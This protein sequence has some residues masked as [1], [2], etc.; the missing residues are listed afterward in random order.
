[1]EQLFFYN[2]S[3]RN[4]PDYSRTDFDSML[5]LNGTILKTGFQLPYPSGPNVKAI[6]L[7]EATVFG[8]FSDAHV[9]FTQTGI[10]MLGVDVKDAG[11]IG[12]II[13]LLSKASGQVIQGFN[14]QEQSLRENRVPTS[15]E[16]DQAAK[17]RILWLA[18]KDLHSAVLN[19]KALAWALRVKPDLKHQNGFVC[20]E[21][22]NL[23]SYLLANELPDKM[24]E[25]G[26]QLASDHCLKKGVVFIHALEGSSTSTREPAL[27]W[28]FLKKGP[29]DGIIYHQ[30]TD[31]S[32]AYKHKWPGFG[33]CLL[34]DG[35]LG[36]RTAALNEPYA[37]KPV[38]SG[39]LYMASAELEALLKKARSNHLQLAV[40][41][42]G[43]R[44]LD[45]V[46]SSY[47]WA[48]QKFG[49]QPLPD[50]I[51]HFILPGPKAIK[52]ARESGA[53]VCIQPAFDFF[54]GGSNGLYAQRLGK[55]RAM[56]CNPFKTLLDFGIPIAAGSDSP[57]TPVDPL[58]SIHALVNHS[59]PDEQIDLNS[60]I[61][62]HIVEPFRFIG[63]EKT[64]GHLKVGYKADFVCLEDD[65]FM[66][67]EARIK[68]IK[69]SQTYING[70]P[71][72]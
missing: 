52:A 16:L 3:G 63:K 30:S 54:W 70:L 59:N 44:A 6:D 61:A 40:H 19:G 45:M 23:L 14:L 71:V 62:L 24:L 41:A 18:R 9:H 56:N 66:I 13:D 47:L 46:T 68:S 31:P 28:N 43:D 22:Y 12:E 58:L 5:V 50:R 8:G 38:A 65:P 39:N 35:S 10:S 48:A 67:P 27:A 53:M 15:N 26:M 51:E 37:D 4:L 60:A 29:L 32:F 64:R 1:M 7:K 36:T 34:A 57:V 49:I 20:G 69:I 11:S 72:G 33:G 21:D 25:E 2:F 17:D 55:E 42:I